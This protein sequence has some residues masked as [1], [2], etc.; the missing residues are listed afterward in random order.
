MLGPQFESA[1]FTANL[2]MTRVV[3]RLFKNPLGVASR[4]RPDF[5][6]LTDSSVGLYSCPSFND[7]HEVDGS[8]CVVVI[9]L[10]TTGRRLCR[11]DREQVWSYIEELIAIGYIKPSTRVDG[12][13]FG[14][15]IA[16][17]EDRVTSYTDKVKIRPMLYDTI[18]ARA[19]SRLLNLYREVK[20][21]PF[22]TDMAPENPR[23]PESVTAARASLEAA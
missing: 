11:D 13:I 16:R 21:A 6:V 5:V 7:G 18:L 2:G 15:Q 20:N 3:Q 1:E 10:K 8:E 23:R 14:D 17:G 12:Y 9:E 19:Q 4:R 22:L